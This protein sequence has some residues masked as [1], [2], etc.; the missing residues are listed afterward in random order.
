MR[1]PIMAINALH[2]A[3]PGRI[4]LG[5]GRGKDGHFAAGSVFHIGDVLAD[6]IRCVVPQRDAFAEMGAVYARA[7]RSS[8]AKV[9][10]QHGVRDRVLLIDA[11]AGQIAHAITE[12]TA[13]GM[14]GLTS[15]RGRKEPFK[16]LRNGT[17]IPVERDMDHLPYS[18]YLGAHESARSR[19]NMATNTLNLGMR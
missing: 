5:A 2:G 3:Q 16:G 8:C 13:A 14:A 7:V 17:G 11:V 4:R 15:V 1:R 12:K 9:H 6:V 10:H 19:S 18:I